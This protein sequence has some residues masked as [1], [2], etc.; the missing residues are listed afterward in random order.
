MGRDRERWIPE[1][2]EALEEEDLP[3]DDAVVVSCPYCGELVELLL[4]V[5]GGAVQDYVEDCEVCCRPWRVRLRM[6]RDGSAEV[7][8]GT[9]DEG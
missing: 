7:D 8:V 6:Q 5:G 2:S 1:V 4:D 9:L 3:F